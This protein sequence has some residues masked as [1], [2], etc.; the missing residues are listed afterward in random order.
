MRVFITGGTTGIGKSLGLLFAQSGAKVGVCGLQSPSEIEALPEGFFY[1]QADVTNEEELKVAVNEFQD[2]HGGL[3]LMIANA[4]LNMPKTKIPDTSLGKKVTQVNVMGVIHAFASSVPHFI[5]QSHGHFVAISSLSA[6]NGLPG[7][8]YYGATKSF[9]SNFCEGLAIDLKEKN[10]HVTC[11]HPGF[12]ATTFT[13]K[14]THPMPFI[15][16]QEEAAKQIH[17]AIINRK[18]HL[19]FPAIPALFMGLLR[20][21]PRK[22]YFFVMKKDLLKLSH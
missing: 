19:Y 20:R 22:V 14:N 21:L 11:V 17:Q 12:I 15:L 16:E 4:G 18:T 7:M 8:S 9:V 3:D 6:L 13:S 5:N 1:Y 10:I 2:T